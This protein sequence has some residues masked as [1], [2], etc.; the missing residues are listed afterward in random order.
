MKNK[1]VLGLLGLS[2]TANL[3]LVFHLAMREPARNGKT[4]AEFSSPEANVSSASAGASATSERGAPVEAQA[5]RRTTLD[6][7][8]FR[9]GSDEELP[10]LIAQLRAAGWPGNLIRALVTELVQERFAAREPVRPFWRR[11]EPNLEFVLEN[12][13]LAAEKRELLER[14]LG[15]DA[16]PAATM[17]AAQRELRY[18]N[19]PPEKLNAIARI[20]RDYDELRARAMAEK[21]SNSMTRINN[22]VLQQELLEAEKLKDLATILT[23]AEVEQYELRNTLTAQKLMTHVAGADL[24]GDEFAALYR[25]HKEFENTHAV[26]GM[27]P[28]EAMAARMEGLVATTERARAVLADD[29]YYKYLEGAD[30]NYA[31]VAR[32]FSQYPT[33]SRATS[34]EVYRL[35]VELQAQLMK[36]SSG[37]N[38]GVPANASV[39]REYNERLVQLLG[40]DLAAE[41]A[42]QGNGRIRIGTATTLQRGGD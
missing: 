39:L 34:V 42:R 11:I 23:P 31:A 13:A 38:R 3:A 21:E 29:R 41:Y 27:M 9:R 16:S 10:Q 20:E 36:S 8:R 6:L 2:L 30:P 40:P 15:A 24:S 14:L 33:I 37:G 26:R 28:P 17:T 7:E 1:T 5:A 25:L 22:I 19:L 18:G 32:F 4:A 12:Q 35:Q